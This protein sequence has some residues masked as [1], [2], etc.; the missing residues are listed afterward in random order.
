M[1]FE[2]RLESRCQMKT[3]LLNKRCMK[4]MHTKILQVKFFALNTN[5]FFNLQIIKVI[6]R[7]KKS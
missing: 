7:S 6:R 1:K 4:I 3:N 2:K 5:Y